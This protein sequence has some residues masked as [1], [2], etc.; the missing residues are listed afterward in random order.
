MKVVTVTEV[1]PA[2]YEEEEEKQRQHQNAS[3]TCGGSKGKIIWPVIFESALRRSN[4]GKQSLNQ[5]RSTTWKDEGAGLHPSCHVTSA[6]FNPNLQQ[7][8]NPFSS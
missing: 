6:S 4:L 5:Q 1:E 7:S 8:Y 2:E 3:C